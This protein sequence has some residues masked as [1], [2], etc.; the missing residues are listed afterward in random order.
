MR[1]L[2]EDHRSCDGLIPTGKVGSFLLRVC[3]V[4]YC[5]QEKHRLSSEASSLLDDN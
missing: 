1:E 4:S 3:F 2:G 5:S